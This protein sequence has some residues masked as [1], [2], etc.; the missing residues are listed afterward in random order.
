MV[1]LGS[2]LSEAEDAA[3]SGGGE[4]DLPMLGGV[5]GRKNQTKLCV[6][7]SHNLHCVAGAR[8]R[9]CAAASRSR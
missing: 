6:M 7:G 8:E 9:G 1:L 3:L 4:R 2:E 5:A